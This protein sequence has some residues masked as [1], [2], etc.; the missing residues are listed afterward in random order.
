[1]QDGA[2]ASCMQGAQH[3]CCRVSLAACLLLFKEVIALVPS[4]HEAQC[5]PSIVTDCCSIDDQGINRSEHEAHR[6]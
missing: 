3:V 6:T 4:H 2:D 1:V 5:S